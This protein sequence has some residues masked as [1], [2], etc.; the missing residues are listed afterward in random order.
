M[1]FIGVKYKG[2]HTY[3]DKTHHKVGVSKTGNIKEV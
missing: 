3:K 2:L 1:G